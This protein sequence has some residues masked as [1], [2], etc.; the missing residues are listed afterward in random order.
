MKHLVK[1]ISL[2]MLIILLGSATVQAQYCTPTYSIGCTYGDGLTLFQLNTINQ[3]I[4]CSG[5]PPYY[6]DYTTL[7]TTLTKGVA[8]TITVQV[9][10]GS[11]YVTV[12]CDYNQNNV[13]D[14]ATETVGQVIGAV[15]ATNYTIPF[16]PP[17]T[18]TTGST[19]LRAMT[20]WISYP[21][22][23]CAAESYGN[24]SD[25]TVNLQPACSGTLAG[26]VKN[27][28][29]N[30]N[31]AGVTVS[32]GTPPL[33]GVTNAAG[34]YTIANVPC[35]SQMVTATMGGYVPYGPTPATI[36]N[37]ATTTLNFCM[38]PLP[39]YVNGVITN[40]CTGTPVIGAKVTQATATTNFVYS[41]G[42]NGV[43]SLGIAGGA[44]TAIT[45][46]KD[47]FVT[48]TIASAT[49]VAPTVYNNVNLPLLES[50]NA[51][52]TVHAL[53]NTG[54][55]AVNIDWGIPQG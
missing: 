7:T 13:F 39:A 46:S 16:T 14:V 4:P 8:Y 37:L 42:P 54:Q 41:T 10:Y 31:L 36:N 29:T 12:W 1:F 53:L 3:V 52:G 51:P 38:T 34:N 25:F 22:G 32:I 5:T 6:H 40:A 26:N 18:A 11:T 50:T 24:C 43:Y 47:G 44:T 48:G 20:E 33:T 19:R 30:A 15:A 35:G 28:S 55:T 2:V 21:T 17:G 27:C 45:V 49:Y 9:G 23:P